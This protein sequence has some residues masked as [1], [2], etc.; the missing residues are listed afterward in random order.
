MITTSGKVLRLLATILLVVVWAGVEPRILLSQQARFGNYTGDRS[1]VPMQVTD[2]TA[3]SGRKPVGRQFNSTGNA[4][5]RTAQLQAPAAAPYSQLQYQQPSY[6]TGAGNYGQPAV[7]QPNFY[8]VPGTAPAAGAIAPGVNGM[9]GSY[10]GAIAPGAVQYPS[11]GYARP[12]IDPRT[13]LVLPPVN[14][15]SDRTA[16]IDVRVTPGTQTGRAIIGGTVNSELG[17]AGQLILEERDFD[18]RRFGRNDFRSGRA[19]VGGGQHLRIE[20]MPGVEVQRYTASWSQPNLFEYLPYSLSVGGFYYTRDL[21]D[22]GEQRAGGRVA[23][24]YDIPAAN[25][26]FSAEM[27]LE[28][29]KIFDPR[30]GGV[31]E[32][33]SVLGSNDVYRA[34][35]RA[36]RDTRDSPFLTKQGSLFELVFDQVFGEYDYSRGQAN[37]SRYF[38]VSQRDDIEAVHTLASSWKFA[39]TG[40]QTPVFENFYAGGYS[41]L[42]GFDFRGASPRKSDVEV[43]G[44]LMFLGSLEYGLPV[45]VDNMVRGVAFVDYGTVEQDLKITSEDFRVALGLGLRISVPA[46]GPAPIALDFAYP[47]NKADTDETRIFTFFVGATR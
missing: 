8:G 36:T 46:L 41:T 19:F 13:G 30:I 40:S 33:D 7:A 3:P 43:G 47:V 32:L 5:Q 9:T 35:F 39:I 15:P 14:S 2:L 10:G 31:A 17:F 4:L 20:L 23:L 34:R 22:W 29:V 12:L 16:P 1:A 37:L 21:R 44:E 18:F 45:T 6:G 11:G 25:V 27:R 28:D 24:G 38:V 26:A 42:R